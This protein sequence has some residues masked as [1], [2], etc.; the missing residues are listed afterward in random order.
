ML[1]DDTYYKPALVRCAKDNKHYESKVRKDLSVK[2]YL[3]MILSH[4]PDLINDYK[5]RLSRWKI[6]LN[7]EICFINPNN[8]PPY[9]PCL[10]FFSNNQ[11]TKPNGMRQI[12]DVH[13]DNEEIR[14]D[15]KTSEIIYGFIK[16]LLDNYQKKKET[17]KHEYNLVFNNIYSCFYYVCRL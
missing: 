1:R 16:S 2:H 13:S 6:Q 15:E 12:F 7:M 9:V 14:S 4:L 10:L 17:D 5:N 8:I 11:D 3:L